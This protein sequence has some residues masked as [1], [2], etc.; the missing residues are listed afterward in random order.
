[1]DQTEKTKKQK[2]TE[3]QL[4]LNVTENYL[5]STGKNDLPSKILAPGKQWYLRTKESHFKT[6]KNADNS[7][8]LLEA[9]I[10]QKVRHE[11]LRASN[12]HKAGPAGEAVGGVQGVRHKNGTTAGIQVF[13]KSY[14]GKQEVV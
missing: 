7:S 1:M 6:W 9:K 4:S 11:I 12:R 5:K 3:W 13:R 14:K 8:A 2:V 10:K